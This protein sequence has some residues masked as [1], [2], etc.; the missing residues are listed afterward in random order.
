VT[1]SAVCSHELHVCAGILSNLQVTSEAPGSILPGF[2]PVVLAGKKILSASSQRARAQIFT[3]ISA[4]RP[5]CLPLLHLTC[6]G[7]SLLIRSP[8]IPLRVVVQDACLIYSAP[9]SPLESGC[10]AY[11][12]RRSRTSNPLVSCPANWLLSRCF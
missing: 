9:W 1:R 11:A 6:R 4:S 7:K 5:S 10:V 3:Q 8:V 2:P 12:T